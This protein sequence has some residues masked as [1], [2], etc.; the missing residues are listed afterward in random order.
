MVLHVSLLSKN[1]KHWL[2]NYRV[3]IEYMLWISSISSKS[4]SKNYMKTVCVQSTKA[5]GW[6]GTSN[7]YTLSSDWYWGTETLQEC[8]P[9]KLN[10]DTSSSFIDF[11][12]YHILNVLM[13]LHS[14]SVIHYTIL[15]SVTDCV[16]LS[17]RLCH[18]ALGFCSQFPIMIM[19]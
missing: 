2:Y 8:P 15:H 11:L 1:T 13:L 18:G 4:T 10:A 3:H 5:S 16:R 7:F 14:V 17:Y 9:L 12:S 19:T 6:S